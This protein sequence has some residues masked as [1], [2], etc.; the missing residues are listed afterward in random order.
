MAV[1]K[2]CGKK[3]LFLHVN[4]EGLCK[5]CIGQQEALLAGKKKAVL[6]QGT[7]YIKLIV[8]LYN[9]ADNYHEADDFDHAMEQ[10][11]Q[12]RETIKK[13]SE[14]DYLKNIMD[15]NIKY[16]IIHKDDPTYPNNII[17]KLYKL[18]DN[19][20]KYIINTHEIALKKATFLPTLESIELYPIELSSE[21]IKKNALSNIEDITFSSITKKS[22]YERLGFF[23]VVDVE[24]TGLTASRD[25]IIEVAAI[26][27]EEWIPVC[28]F[29]TFIKPKKEI[30]PEITD[31]N[32]ITNDMVANAPSIQAVIPALSDFIGKSAIVGHNLLFDIKFLYKNGL[33][34]F[35]VKRKYYDT[36]ELAKKILT[37]A[38]SSYDI[39]GDVDNYKL[40]TLCDYYSIRDNHYAHRAASDCLATG[41]LF[42]IFVKERIG[43]DE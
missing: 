36:L 14:L 15:Q 17:E 27:F 3:G 8:S 2:K 16:E 23:T 32:G 30:T 42:N 43:I 24:T 21:K 26:R 22:N 41:Y 11:T 29:E 12:I 10:C 28:K 1:C 5:K 13:L 6:A 37:K 40:T 38:K 33:D 4:A 9:S 25:E 35:E 34:F 39:Y 20:E 18:I 31:I 7:D 19:C